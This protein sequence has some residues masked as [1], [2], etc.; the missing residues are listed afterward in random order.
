MANVTYEQGNEEKQ[1]LFLLKK[2]PGET[3]TQRMPV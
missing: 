3:D 1:N 2:Q